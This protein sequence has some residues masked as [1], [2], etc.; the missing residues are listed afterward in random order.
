MSAQWARAGRWLT[1]LI[2][3][4]LL[5]VHGLL[6][7]IG[8]GGLVELAVDKPPWTPFSNLELP[9][10]M[11]LLQWL[12]MLTAGAVF[13]AGYA[14]RLR[15]LPHMMA[16]IYAVMAAVCALQTFTMLS[17]ADRFTNMAIE[18]AEYAVILVYLYAAPPM[19]ARFGVQS[20]A[21]STVDAAA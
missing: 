11:L 13:I 10:W 3:A 2:A 14:M 8:A 6:I 18:Y 16:G 4:I 5:A 19:K 12:L 17:N 7:V 15:A 9:G 20:A 1:W 21:D